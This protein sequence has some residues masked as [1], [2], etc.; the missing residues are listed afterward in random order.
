MQIVQLVD[1]DFVNFK[2]PAMFIGFPTCSFKCDTESGTQICQNWALASAPKIEITYDEL[3]QRYLAN[4]ITTAVVCGGLEPF[5][6]MPDLQNLIYAF[7]Q[8]TDDVIV[9][10][11]G[12][13]E[14]EAPNDVFNAF[15]TDMCIKNIIVKYGRFRPNEVQ[16]H[17]NTL[18]VNLAS[19]NQYA[20]HV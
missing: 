10:Y 18:G 19:N 17:D 3:V 12:Y 9:V 2:Q 8:H 6:S 7:R 5:D 20:I 13:T 11:T 4:P 1:E 16:H 15:I 14:N